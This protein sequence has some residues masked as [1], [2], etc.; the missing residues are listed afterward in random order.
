MAR[1]GTLSRSARRVVQRRLGGCHHQLL[2]LPAHGIEH[3]LELVVGRKVARQWGEEASR[4]VEVAI[5]ELC[6]RGGEALRKAGRPLVLGAPRGLGLLLLAPA[7]VGDH[8][9]QVRTAGQ[10]VGG[11]RPLGQQLGA[12]ELRRARDRGISGGLSAGFLGE[13]LAGEQL[14]GRAHLARLGERSLGL[15]SLGGQRLV[16]GELDGGLLACAR[17]LARG[18]FQAVAQARQLRSRWPGP[19]VEVVATGG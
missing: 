13:C 6:S 1:S 15:A 10:L 18:Q 9:R 14:G 3:R 2:S 16:A 11:T 8:A 12:G 4:F 5:G 19:G 7:L 17:I